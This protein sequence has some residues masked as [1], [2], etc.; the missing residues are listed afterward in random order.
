MGGNM[1]NDVLGGLTP[2]PEVSEKHGG[3][4]SVASSIAGGKNFNQ[5]KSI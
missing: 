4:S 2:F 5:V 1:A 3:L